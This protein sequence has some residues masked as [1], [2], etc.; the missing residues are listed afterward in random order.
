MP[1]LPLLPP[2]MSS[3]RST[4]PAVS[5][6]IFPHPRPEVQV[7]LQ[8]AWFQLLSFTPF[9][10]P[11]AT[12]R[13]LHSATSSRQ[14]SPSS[15]SSLATSAATSGPMSLSTAATFGLIALFDARYLFKLKLM[16]PAS[17]DFDHDKAEEDHIEKDE[18]CEPTFLVLVQTME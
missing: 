14:S 7:L 13:T 10:G 15:F 12:R 1:P 8:H 9:N 18:D 2:C 5:P 4:L 16:S 3:S 6:A 11:I 17:P